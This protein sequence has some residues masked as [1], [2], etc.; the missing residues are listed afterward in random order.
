[1]RRS[2]AKVTPGA[3]LAF[4]SAGWKRFMAVAGA[5]EIPLAVGSVLEQI[6]RGTEPAF[7]VFPILWFVVYPVEFAALCYA[8]VALQRGEQAG[9]SSAYQHVFSGSGHFIA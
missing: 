9:I 3:L 6:A 5:V 2:E 8:A 1:M 7:L 4:Y